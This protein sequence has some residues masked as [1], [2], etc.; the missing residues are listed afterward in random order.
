MGKAK[1]LLG[2][3]IA[4]LAGVAGWQIASCELANFEL[5]QCGI[6]RRK[7]QANSD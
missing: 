2:L 6:S 1:L 5:R 3:A 7:S 4:A